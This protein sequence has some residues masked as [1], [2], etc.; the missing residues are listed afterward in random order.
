[1]TGIKQLL[2]QDKAADLRGMWENER[3][4]TNQVKGYGVEQAFPEF[5]ARR[6]R[7]L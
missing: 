4:F 3:D 1:V 5:I 6:G 2:L 7:E